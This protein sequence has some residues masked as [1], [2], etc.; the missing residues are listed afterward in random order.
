MIPADLDFET[1]VLVIGGGLTAT[2]AA[3]AAAQAGADVVL[4]DKGYC[5]TSGVTATAGPNHWWAPPGRRAEAIDRQMERSR[6]LGDADWMSR[7]LDLTW[8]SLPRLAGYYDFP[9]DER[10]EGR[11]RALR[12]PE[13]L[14]AMRRLVEDL[15]VK[16]LDHHPALELLVHADGAV[17][18]ARGLRRQSS[19][20]WRA[21][22]GAVILATGGCA[23]LS[24]LL[25]SHTNTGDGLL[26]AA[27]AGAELSGMEFTGYYTAS[28]ARSTM[29]RS[30]SYA[31]AS[32]RDDAGRPL[33]IPAGESTRALARALLSG[34]V[35][36]RFDRMPARFRER[37]HLIQPNALLPFAR[38]GVDPFEDWFEVTLRAEGTVRG[39][40]GLKV[41]DDDCQ[42]RVPGLF[43]AG[44]AAS[45]ELVAGAIS[46]G[47]AQ[48]SAWA[49]SSGQW[50]GRAAAIRSYRHGRRAETAASAVGEAGLRG[51]SAD[52]VQ[53]V[54]RSV[55]AEMLPYDKAL[56]RS[57]AGL[58]RSLG[59]LDEAWAQ[60]RDLG[61]EG[62]GLLRSREA[63][64]MA[65]TA[66]WC[67]TAALARAESR[68][69]HVREDAP[70]EDVRLTRRQ[71]VS[72]LDVVTSR[73]E[74]AAQVS[75]AVA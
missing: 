67:C 70:E 72:G 1:D 55:Q 45:R 52:G 35:F 63:A 41:A 18:G 13:Y 56:F 16:V 30:V 37:L 48:N 68:G 39:V 71:T 47:G 25:G 38:S 61:G 29:T 36:C 60:A 65:A 6:G 32:Y 59:A 23:F 19:G 54:V 64:A 73:F 57:G 4:V 42:T 22:A 66:R 69:L 74:P 33:D 9:G 2:W 8:T 12:G 5:G 17:A 62:R 20:D 24:R 3:A 75:E 7:V 26:M 49:L 11:F 14:R 53:A 10:G 40:G 44:D 43:A 15:G 28:P 27:E 51:R 31:F 58:T 46:G 50:A 21:R 34:P